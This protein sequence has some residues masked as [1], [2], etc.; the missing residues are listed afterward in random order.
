MMELLI[1]AGLVALAMAGL[2]VGLLAGRGCLRK[3]C[4]LEGSAASGGK[5]EKCPTCGRTR[6][7]KA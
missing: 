2:A 6:A 4:G 5:P 1:A 3:T 7:P